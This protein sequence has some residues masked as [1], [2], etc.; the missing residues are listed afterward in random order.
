MEL[1]FIVESLVGRKKEKKITDYLFCS[2]IR[3]AGG[4]VYP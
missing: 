2:K 3:N 4:L 1:D